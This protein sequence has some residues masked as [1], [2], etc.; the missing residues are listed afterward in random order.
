MDFD[1][2][3]EGIE[4]QNEGSNIENESVGIQNEGLNALNNELANPENEVFTGQKS[5]DEMK[6][7]KNYTDRKSTR[8]N[9]SHL[10]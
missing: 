8:L 3:N 1:A 10:A 5:G 6:E 4:I 2:Q 7:F 9:S